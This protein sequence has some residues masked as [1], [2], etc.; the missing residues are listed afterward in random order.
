[1]RLCRNNIASKM[2][3]YTNNFNRRS[4]SA[5]TLIPTRRERFAADYPPSYI[6]YFQLSHFLLPG[7]LLFLETFSLSRDIVVLYAMRA[8]YSR[9]A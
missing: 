4:S 3:S 6:H 5:F 8:Y 9:E 7:N 2:E 1:M